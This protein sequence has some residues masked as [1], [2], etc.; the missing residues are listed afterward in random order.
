[1]PGTATI[2]APKSTAPKKSDLALTLRPDAPPKSSGGGGGGGGG[3]G[4]KEPKKVAVKRKSETVQRY[5]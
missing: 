4:A 2:P 3:G 1:V 5:K